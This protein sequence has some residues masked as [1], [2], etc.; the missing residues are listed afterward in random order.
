MSFSVDK[1]ILTIEGRRQSQ[2]DLFPAI[3]FSRPKEL[4]SRQNRLRSIDAG[5]WM[6]FS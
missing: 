4:L 1:L 6:H 3:E 5:W 2:V